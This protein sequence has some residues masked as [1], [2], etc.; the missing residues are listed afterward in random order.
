[1]TVER[2]LLFKR[3][4]VDHGDAKMDV[5]QLR[6]RL[7]DDYSSYIRSF[8][9]IRDERISRLVDQEISDGLLWPDPLIQL[10]PSL[11]QKA[12]VCRNRLPL[13]VAL[14]FSQHRVHSWQVLNPD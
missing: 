2:P 3:E 9:Q 1:M 11:S 12:D 10:N 7:V 5:F 4:N 6:N 8:I 14:N 13:C